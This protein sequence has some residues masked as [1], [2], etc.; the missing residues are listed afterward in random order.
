M[1]LNILIVYLSFYIVSYSS[2]RVTN[3][4]TNSILALQN[5]LLKP[6]SFNF[7]NHWSLH[8]KDSFRLHYSFKLLMN[9]QSEKNSNESKDNM[10]ENAKSYASSAIIVML[11][12][13]TIASVSQA[14]FTSM[15]LTDSFNPQLFDTSQ[16]QPV[17]PASD[18]LYQFLKSLA[19]SFVGAENVVQFGPLIASVLL[20]IRL[21]LC[22]FESFIYE[23]VIPFIKAKGLS[24][25]LPFH[26]TLETFL[27]GTIFA[28]ASNF[29]LLGSTKI[30]AVLLIY[31]DTLVGMP[32]RFVGNIVKKFSSKSAIADTIGN[33]LKVFGEIVGAVRNA[34]ES[35][36]TFVGRYLVVATTAY[37]I[38]KFLHF[39]V[40]PF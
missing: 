2:L 32:T 34:V 35:F 16:F 31:F 20:R 21:E 25:I 1:I 8:D 14:G 11:T 40:F 33:V 7:N 30:F 10:M 23:A 28:V 6:I 26:E 3:H 12:V 13:L 38:F 9:K 24:W 27:A 17:C 22:V 36:D 15:M 39:K 37:V 29:I 5:D 4:Q 19:N 18:S